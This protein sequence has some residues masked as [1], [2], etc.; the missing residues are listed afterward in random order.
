M[1]ELTP[2]DARAALV[3]PTDSLAI[4]L[5]PGQPPAFVEALGRRVDW[6]DLRI[7]GALLTV[8]SEVFSHPKVHYLSGFLGP[9]DRILRDTGGTSASR[10]RTSASSSRCSPTRTRG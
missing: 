10:R 2:D 7:Y 1:D 6:E 8:L 4:P 5:G 9:L 3:R